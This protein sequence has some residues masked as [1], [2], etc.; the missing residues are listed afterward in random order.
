MPEA[1][2]EIHKVYVEADE[3]HVAMQ[4]R[5]SKE[6]KL[7]NVYDSKVSV[8]RGAGSYVGGARFPDGKLRPSYGPK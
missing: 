1:K 4:K 3:D 6:M 5:H 7:I 8:C 2:P